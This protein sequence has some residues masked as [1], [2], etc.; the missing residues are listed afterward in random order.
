MRGH[1]L[2]KNFFL[3]FCLGQLRELPNNIRHSSRKKTKCSCWGGRKKESWRPSK[4]TSSTKRKIFSWMLY[5]L[6]LFPWPLLKFIFIVREVLGA[7]YSFSCTCY[8][9][10]GFTFSSIHSTKYLSNSI[11]NKFEIFE[12]EFSKERRDVSL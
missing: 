9:K 5:G 8:Q 10:S 11:E 3:V 7:G 1:F 6:E 12:I 2:W 4:N